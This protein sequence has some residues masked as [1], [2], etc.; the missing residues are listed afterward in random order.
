VS[1][2]APSPAFRRFAWA[3]L[4]WNLAVVAWGGFV[5][6][7]GSG[8]GCGRHWPAC[9]GE[10]LPRSPAVETLVEF[11]H[12]ATSGVAI[13]LVAA[14]LVW[15]LRAL[16]RGDPSRR[17]AAWA[18]A[19]MVVEAL[20]GAALV[21]FG[22]VARDAS[23]ARAWVMPI[24]LVNTFLLLGALA[25]VARP[26]AGGGLRPWVAAALAAVLLAGASGAVAALGD[27]LYP[28]TSLGDALREELGAGGRTL[29]RL[30]VVHPFV[31]A[32]A[33]ALALLAARTPAVV[34]AVVLQVGVGALNVLLLAPVGLQ[35]LHLVLADVLWIALVLAAASPGG[36]RSR[37]GAV[38]PRGAGGTGLQAT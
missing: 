15:A 26:P 19:F 8:A 5:R 16:P 7:T 17:A 18:M 24:H 38:T 30:R 25:L 1:A 11:T 6:A 28:A 10:V 22:W 27:T 2:S 31:A 23:L 9:N 34:A 12:R 35:I 20:V 4:G 32:V 3:V 13:L 29:V 37:Q 14:L 21:L 36:A 33:A